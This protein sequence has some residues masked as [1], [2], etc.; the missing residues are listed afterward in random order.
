[1]SVPLLQIFERIFDAAVLCFL[2]MSSGGQSDEIM[3]SKKTYNRLIWANSIIILY[4]GLPSGYL[5]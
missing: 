2:V 1:V 5:T 4:H 3:G